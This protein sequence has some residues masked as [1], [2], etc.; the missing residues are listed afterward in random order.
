M[1]LFLFWLAPTAAALFDEMLAVPPGGWRAVTLSLRQRPA[2]LECHFEVRRGPAVRVWLV[3]RRDVDRFGR[4]HAVRPLAISA[5]AKR[6]RLR[7]AL[8]LGEFALVVDNR[9]S[10]GQ[11]VEVAVRAA[12]DFMAIQARELPPQKRALIVALSLLF[13][14]TLAYWAVRR[15]GPLFAVRLRE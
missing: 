4:R 12:L 2:V 5:H 8:G 11:E 1:I 10:A 13:L 6:G 15:F 14:L 9:L 7:Q 3:E